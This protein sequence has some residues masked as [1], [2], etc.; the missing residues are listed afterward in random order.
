MPSDPAAI[1]AEIEA[2]R[3]HLAATVD[4]LVVRAH[5]KVIARRGAEAAKRHLRAAT[6]TPDGQLRVERIAALAGVAL[7]LVVLAVRNR[8]R[9][10]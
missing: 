10:R 9:H 4:E 3:A 1:E 2:R 8:R 5:P 7:L 6:T